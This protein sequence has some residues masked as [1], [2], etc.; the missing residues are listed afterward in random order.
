MT[1]ASHAVSDTAAASLFGGNLSASLIED[2]A[3][4]GWAHAPAALEP[5]RLVLARVLQGR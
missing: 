1:L 5:R 4:R 3:A 2:L